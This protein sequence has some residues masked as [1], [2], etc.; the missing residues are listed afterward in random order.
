MSA[1]AIGLPSILARSGGF[2]I[3]ED[4]DVIV[5]SLNMQSGPGTGYRVLT[6]LREGATG[7]VLEGPVFGD[8]YA[9]YKV[10][11]G[12]VGWV[13]SACLGSSAPPPRHRGFAFRSSTDRRTSATR[14]RSTVARSPPCRRARR[15]A[16]LR[17][18]VAPGPRATAGS[19]SGSRRRPRWKASSP[20]RSPQRQRERGGG[21][22][23]WPGSV[24]SFLPGTT[25]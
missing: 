20:T 14:R 4:V 12:T 24:S 22:P 15:C 21:R 1:T 18:A 2:H 16:S 5:Y 25:A 11:V 3:G 23:G 8:V 10:N 17:L 13:A 19:R 7:T 9:W 6:V